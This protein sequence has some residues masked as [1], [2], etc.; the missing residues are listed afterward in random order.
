MARYTL[1][2]SVCLYKRIK[3]IM[4]ISP[5]ALDFL[6]P[7]ASLHTKHTYATKLGIKSNKLHQNLFILKYSKIQYTVHSTQHYIHSTMNSFE[8]FAKHEQFAWLHCKRSTF[9]FDTDGNAL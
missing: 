9:R 1:F 4:Y 3:Y 6:K 5:R 8:E 7:K 2:V